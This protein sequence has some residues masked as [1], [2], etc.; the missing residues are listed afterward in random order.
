MSDKKQVTIYY[1]DGT[2]ETRD[3]TPEEIPQDEK[4]APQ[5]T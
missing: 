4:P 5:P 3:M 2:T 1:A